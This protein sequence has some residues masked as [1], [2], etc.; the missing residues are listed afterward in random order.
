[1]EN[2]LAQ[3]LPGPSVSTPSTQS[4]TQ[5]TEQQWSGLTTDSIKS[6]KTLRQDSSSMKKES[7]VWRNAIQRYYDELRRGGIKGPAIDKDLWNIKSPVDLLEQVKDLEPPDLQA[8][9]TWLGALHRL[10]PILL[11]LNDFASAT[12]WALGMNG[13]VAGV[14]WGSIRLILNVSEFSIL[15]A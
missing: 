8:S 13:K 7:V 15:G 10:E 14:L 5:S 1:M 6:I 11:S 3:E 9:R 2:S 12:A 4:T